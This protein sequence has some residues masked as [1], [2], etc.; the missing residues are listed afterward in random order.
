VYKRQ[1]L[2]AA[3]ALACRALGVGGTAAEV[4]LLFAAMPTAS[5]AYILARQ[6]GGD[7]PLM[8]AITTAQTI[9]AAAAI[10]LVLALAAP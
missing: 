5:S 8:A 6:L 3:T 2:P 7:A 10:P 9:A 4:A 1:V